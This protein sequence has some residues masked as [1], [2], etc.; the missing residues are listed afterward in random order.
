LRFEFDLKRLPG[1]YCQQ[2]YI[3]STML[4]V[5]CWITFWLKLRAANVRLTMCGLSFLLMTLCCFVTSLQVPKTHYSKAIDV[6]T[7]TCMAF[8]FVALIREFLGSWTNAIS[9]RFS[10]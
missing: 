2:V 10:L 6:F 8:V 3:P 4:V 5:V 9:L 7:G 1:F